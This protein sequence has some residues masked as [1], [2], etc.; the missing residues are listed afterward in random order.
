MAFRFKAG[1]KSDGSGTVHVKPEIWRA[2]KGMVGKDHSLHGCMQFAEFVSETRA[3]VTYTNAKGKTVTRLLEW[4]SVRWSNLRTQ[5]I[6]EEAAR[7]AAWHAAH[8]EAVAELPQGTD[9]RIVENVRPALDPDAAHHRA[10]P[11]PKF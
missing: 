11:R 6:R 9:E 1:K 2:C 10:F 4:D 7:R 8:A 5:D 3:R